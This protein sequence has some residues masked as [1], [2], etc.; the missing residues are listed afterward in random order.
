MSRQ[1]YGQDESMVCIMDNLLVG[2]ELGTKNIR[3][4]FL[5]EE[6]KICARREIAA[7]IDQGP[8]AVIRRMAELTR[9]MVG[10][11]GCEMR[12]VQAIGVGAP[13]P[14]N[15][16]TGM[17]YSPPNL[18]GWDRVPLG[19]RLAVLTGAPVFIENDAKSGGWGEYTLGAGL[20]CRSMVGI[21]LGSGIGGAIIL[22]GALYPGKDGMAGEIGHIPIERK[23]GRRCV[24]GS[25]GCV[26]AYVTPATIVSRF[27]NKTSQGWKSSLAG[28]GEISYQ[29]I[30]RAANEGDALS[31]KIVES[32]GKYLGILAAAIVNFINPER[33]VVSGHMVHFGTLLLE[34]MRR[35]C[36]SRCFGPG[37]AVDI[38]PSQLGRD[39]GVL[40]AA[41]LARL[42]CV[43]APIVR[44]GDREAVR[45]G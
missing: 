43:A 7:H 36:L 14:L 40:G 8:D 13:G 39:A 10:E 17:L 3:C 45:E 20:G 2:M 31:S 27:R 21:T 37:R 15:A 28:R 33:I 41:S 25:R 16:Q 1:V 18:G 32:S 24:C 26:E 42:R 34:S 9:E 22:D 23:G 44:D 30:F 12:N 6:G 11:L 35:E 5:A 19:P 38:L 29:D 4:V